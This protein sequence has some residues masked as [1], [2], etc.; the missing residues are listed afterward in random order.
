MQSNDIK[1]RKVDEPE[2]NSLPR[3]VYLIFVG[4][5]P[6]FA[7]RSTGRFIPLP[8]AEQDR[9]REKHICPPEASQ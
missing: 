9:L 2:F 6:I 5:K 8:L 3:G 1:L 7:R 4:D